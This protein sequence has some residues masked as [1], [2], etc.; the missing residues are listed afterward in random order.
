MDLS[1]IQEEILLKAIKMIRTGEADEAVV[2][3]LHDNKMT[4]IQAEQ[5][6]REVKTTIRNNATGKVPKNWRLA[7][8]KALV[9]GVIFSI[10]A[11]VIL[12]ATTGLVRLVAFVAIGIGIS[13]FV[14][15]YVK[16]RAIRKEIGKR[17]V[18]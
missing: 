4:H 7:I 8:V 16:Y 5:F 12:I 11:V 6:L 18:S 9:P 17:N 1:R 14:G 15:A 3:F 10:A 2:A 13:S